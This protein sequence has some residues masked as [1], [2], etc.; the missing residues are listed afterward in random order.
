[1]SSYFAPVTP[2][3]SQNTHAVAG[4]AELEKK[5]FEKKPALGDAYFTKGDLSLLEFTQQQFD[6]PDSSYISEAKRAEVIDVITD[7]AQKILGHDIASD[8]Q[9]QLQNKYTV[10]TA[11]HHGPI[12]DPS[13]LN[14]NLLTHYYSLQNDSK[15]KNILVL[16][17]A[18]VSFDNLSFPR[19]H[20]IHGI[21]DNTVITNQLV[22]FPRKVRPLTVSSHPG[23]TQES[24]QNIHERTDAWVREGNLQK[25]QAEKL[26][27]IVEDVYNEP[28]LFDFKTFSEQVTKTNHSLWKKLVGDGEESSNLIY[29]EQENIVNTLI[30]KHHLNHD[31][32]INHIL[33]DETYASLFMK[34]FNGVYGGFTLENQGGT[35]L[36]WALPKDQKYRIQLWKKGNMLVSADE[37]YKIELTPARIEKALLEKELLPSTLLSFIILAFYYGL[38]LQGGK[39]QTTYLTHMK[40]AYQAF[41][42]ELANIEEITVSEQIPTTKQA[43]AYPCIAFLSTKTQGIV[44][45]TALDLLLYGNTNYTDVLK[46]MSET[47]TLRQATARVLPNLYRMFFSEEAQEEHLKAISPRDIDALT[48]FDRL[49]Q[50]IGSLE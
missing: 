18:N 44:P 31:T 9:A 14:N 26:T 10:I 47:I 1:M 8:I 30:R 15:M 28:S 33:F 45:A 2:I 49:I 41:N 40:Q 43:L 38:T 25:S 46:V 35:Y 13:F 21:N 12:T 3:P 19:G 22:F 48:G 37:S 7:D 16:A 42:T 24:I 36:F 39:S 27:E 34:H 6:L 32:L 4:L 11:N 5:V 50:P 29:L 17:C 20:F 23:Y